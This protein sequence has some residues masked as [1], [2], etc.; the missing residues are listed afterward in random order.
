M[1]G[2]LTVLHDNAVF[3]EPREVAITK[4]LAHA[5]GQEGVRGARAVRD[6]GMGVEWVRK[7]GCEWDLQVR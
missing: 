3:D 4:P 1:Q 2:L 5:R 6:R 7:G